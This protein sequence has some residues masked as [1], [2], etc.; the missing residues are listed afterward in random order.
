MKNLFLL[1]LLSCFTVA[2]AQVSHVEF[3]ENLERECYAEAL[4]LEC[5][6]NKESVIDECLEKKKN[7]FSSKCRNFHDERKSRKTH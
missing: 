2:F 7:L 4:K 5:I 3:D 1:F 6:D